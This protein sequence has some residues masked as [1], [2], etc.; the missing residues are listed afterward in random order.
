MV[1]MVTAIIVETEVI[2]PMVVHFYFNHILIHIH[3][4]YIV[5][6]EN[7]FSHDK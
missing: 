1:G 3:T 4:L 7:L 5:I 2:G 6:I